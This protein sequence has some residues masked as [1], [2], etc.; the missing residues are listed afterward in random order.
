MFNISWISFHKENADSPRCAI[1]SPYS[2]T[3]R[4]LP[5]PLSGGAWNLLWVAITQWKVIEPNIFC[6]RSQ[7]VA[8]L[9]SV[10]DGKI[11]KTTLM[12]KWGAL[13]SPRRPLKKPFYTR[14]VPVT[15][16]EIYL[17]SPGRKWRWSDV[18]FSSSSSFH[19]RQA[20]CCIGHS[21]PVLLQNTKYKYKYKYKDANT[22]TSMELHRQLFSSS[23]AYNVFSNIQKRLPQQK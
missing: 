10:S 7:G 17:S 9:V 20:H 11:Q 19:L 8:A 12:L 18:S 13:S 21:S 23:R 2:Q 16:Y 22:N 3:V 4:R 14:Q 1:L 6:T 15:D 5:Q